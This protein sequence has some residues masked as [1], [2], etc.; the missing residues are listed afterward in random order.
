LL[1]TG[2]EDALRAIGHAL[3]RRRAHRVTIVE[4]EQC[5][6]VCGYQPTERHRE[7]EYSRFEW[8]LA[9]EELTALLNEAY[10]RR[11]RA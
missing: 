1:P 6:L 3:D 7:N 10:Y 8:V 4:L 2:Y 11:S 9:A 5:L